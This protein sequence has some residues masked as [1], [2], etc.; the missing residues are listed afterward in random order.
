[1]LF[2]DIS[3]E[4][5]VLIISAIG[6]PKVI[7]MVLEGYRARARE[8]RDK[9]IAAKVEA[10]R[11]EAKEGSNKLEAIAK[12]S[13]ATHT[14][15]NSNMGAQLKLTAVATRRLAALTNDQADLDAADLADKLLAE[16]EA[17]QAVVDS[18]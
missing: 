17:K 3:A 14:L 16:H 10:V 6:I 8:L 1:M 12:V 9:E 18:Q 7:D 15:V 2:A 13:E 5:W 11:V 4:G